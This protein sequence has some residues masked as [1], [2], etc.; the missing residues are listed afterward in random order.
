QIDVCNWFWGAEPLTVSG[1]GGIFHY[2]DGREVDDHVFAIF[3]YPNDKVMTFSSIT[4]NAFD[5]YYDQVMG[6]K[7]TVYLTGEAKAMMFA[8][9]QPKTAAISVTS[10]AG[11][12]SV[13]SA[14][15]SRSADMAGGAADGTGMGGDYDPFT[16]YREELN[17]FATA[18]RKGDPS[19]VGCDGRA[20]RKAA[21]A[22]LKSNE[23]ME[24][25]TVESCVIEEPARA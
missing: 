20:G 23:A 13:S 15:K 12:G 9:G 25:G 10:S 5:N 1:T 22:V 2:K 17:M 24:K 6:T 7:M 8:E 16:A 21:I 4:T 19:L 3:R 18:I 11:G 14:T